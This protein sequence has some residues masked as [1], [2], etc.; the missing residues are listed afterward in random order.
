MPCGAANFPEP[1]FFALLASVSRVQQIRKQMIIDLDEV[2]GHLF[3]HL[4]RHNPFT[5]SGICQS[6]KSVGYH[7][8]FWVGSDLSAIMDDVVSSIDNVPKLCEH[9]A[10]LALGL[11]A[12]LLHLEQAS[13]Q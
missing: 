1:V 6:S 2:G 9:L 5:N 7:K 13:N 11:P 8:R 12:M 10:N 4:R 3:Q